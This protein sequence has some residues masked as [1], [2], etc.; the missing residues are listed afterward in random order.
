M[1]REELELLTDLKQ[2]CNKAGQFFLEFTDGVLSIEAEQAYAHSLFDVG[3]RLLAHAKSRK[4]LVLDGE[5]TQL[6]IDAELVRVDYELR[7]L[8]PGSQPGDE[9]S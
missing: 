2:V 5:P 3:D 7:E 1:T 8:P 4:G 9:W 6:V